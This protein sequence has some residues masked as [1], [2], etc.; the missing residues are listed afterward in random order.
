MILTL[1]KKIQVKEN[2]VQIILPKENWVNDAS[3]NCYS[4]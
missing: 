2:H 1:K 4:I 3:K